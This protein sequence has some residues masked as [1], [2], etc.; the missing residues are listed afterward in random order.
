MW[1]IKDSGGFPAPKNSDGK[2]SVPFWSQLDFVEN[3]IQTIPS[4]GEFVPYELSLEEFMTKWVPGMTKDGLLVGLNWSGK[5][6]TGF[7][8]EPIVVK[9]NIELYMSKTK[10]ENGDKSN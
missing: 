7:D 8:Y 4:Y 6:V 3:I 10:T 5:M 1:T 2:R 9:K